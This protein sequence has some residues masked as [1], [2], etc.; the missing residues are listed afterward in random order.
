MK[1]AILK[2]NET[3]HAGCV[4]VS[5][6]NY[7]F[8]NGSQA[9]T[10]EVVIHGTSFK[11]ACFKPISDDRLID[12]KITMSN[13]AITI[14]G[15]KILYLCGPLLQDKIRFPKKLWLSDFISTEGEQ[16]TMEDVVNYLYRRSNFKFKLSTDKFRW[17]YKNW[18]NQIINKSD[19]YLDM[20]EEIAAAMENAVPG[21]IKKDKKGFYLTGSWY[22]TPFTK[23]YNFQT[24][25]YSLYYY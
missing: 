19:Y 4:I 22:E 25:V 17:G 24:S 13:G 16:F 18:F 2:D 10:P 6:E 20:T 23:D 21:E 5:K 15:K 3:L 1:T 9:K 14:T 12:T 8:L 11:N 7:S